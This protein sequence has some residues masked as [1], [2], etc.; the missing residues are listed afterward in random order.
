MERTVF[1]ISDRTGISAETLGHTLLSQFQNIEFKQVTYPF[2]DTVAKAQEVIVEINRFCESATERPLLF[3][4]VVNPDIQVVIST[5]QAVIVD[6]FNTFIGRLEKEL[7]VAS[8]HLVGYSHGVKNMQSY[9]TRIEAINFALSCDD[10]LNVQNY[11]PAELILL[12]VSRSGKTPTSLYLALQFGIFVA[13]YPLNEDD[14]HRWQL[15]DFLQKNHQKLFGLVI[16]A[17]RLHSIRAER[18]PGSEYASLQQCQ[19]EIAE[20]KKIFNR[21]KIPFLETTTA[22]IEEIATHILAIMGLRRQSF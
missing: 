2:I 3:A 21:E 5:C 9:N 17:E 6:F 15:P 22:S 11:A 12:G 13:N 19:H 16:S 10:G 14:F 8:S 20:V 7:Q 18:R 4:T 1:F